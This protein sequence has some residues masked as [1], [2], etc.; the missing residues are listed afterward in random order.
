MRNAILILLLCLTAS[1]TF[2]F[3]ESQKDTIPQTLK[4][5]MTFEKTH[6]N[7]GKV[8]KGEKYKMTFPFTNTG[9]EDLEIEIVSAC[10]CTTLDWPRM[11]I[12]PGEKG[13]IKATFDSN[14]KDASETIEIDINL[15][16]IDPKTGYGMLKIVSYS[17]EM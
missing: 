4:A 12:K 16:N 13:I 14:L 1:A 17:F 15:S 3:G 7:L 5:E 10:E 11:P 2:S 9:N 6:I 8:T